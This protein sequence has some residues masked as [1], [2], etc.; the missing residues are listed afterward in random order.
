MVV[1]FFVVFCGVLFLVLGCFLM[2]GTL[3]SFVLVRCCFWCFVALFRVFVLV[4]SVRP[5]IGPWFPRGLRD[6]AAK[7][8][9]VLSC[10]VD[11][12]LNL[13]S[14]VGI[15]FWCFY[16]WFLVGVV[17]IAILRATWCLVFTMSGHNC[18]C[19]MVLKTWRCLWWWCW[20]YLMVAAGCWFMVFLVVRDSWWFMFRDLIGGVAD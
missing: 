20:R 19:W 3:L 6:V 15:V 7:C 2:M 12:V 1:W 16:W 13:Y 8:D 10:L 14:I 4:G 18:C 11:R 17:K 5:C 9:R